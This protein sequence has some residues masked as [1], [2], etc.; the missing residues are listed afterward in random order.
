MLN[1]TKK[2][3][4]KQELFVS[5]FAVD[6]NATQ[7][8]I[9]AGYSAK[10]AKSQGQRL[11]TNADVSFA[12]AAKQA[13]RFAKVEITADRVLAEMASIA[14]HDVG[15]LLN[16]DGTMKP[17]GEIDD[18]ARAAIAGPARIVMRRHDDG[19]R[20]PFAAGFAPPTVYHPRQRW[21]LLRAN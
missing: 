11:L 16:D 17:I 4:A 1:P 20:A 2:L 3:S 12:I 13:R 14:F 5:W 8:A 9:R 15:K 10:T 7:A 18:D 6:G 21:A 19:R